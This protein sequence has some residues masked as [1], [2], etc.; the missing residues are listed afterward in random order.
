MDYKATICWDC[1][2]AVKGCSWSKDFKPVDGWEAIPT[3]ILQK[4]NRFGRYDKTLNSYIVISCPQ[5]VEG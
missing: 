1:K 4:D 5:F 2:N 3:K